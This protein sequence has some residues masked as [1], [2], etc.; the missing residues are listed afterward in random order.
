[1]HALPKL[2]LGLENFALEQWP[3]EAKCRPGPTMKV[4][5]FPHLKFTYRISNER[6]SYF[7]LIKD[8]RNNKSYWTSQLNT[9]KRKYILFFIVDY[10]YCFLCLSTTFSSLFFLFF[11][12][13]TYASMDQSYF[14]K[15]SSLLAF[16]PW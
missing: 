12:F 4:P 9:H 5:P 1:M 8:I 3:S 11:G 6:R 13:F 10:D 14:V 7:V 2:L 15:F 16:R